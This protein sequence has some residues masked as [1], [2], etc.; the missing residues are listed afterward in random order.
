MVLLVGIGN[1]LKSDDNIG[2][3]V[4]EKLKNDFDILVAETNPEAYLSKMKGRDKIIFIDAVDFKGEIGEVQLFNL[5]DIQDLLYATHNIPVSMLKK[6]LPGVEIQVIG[7]QP[8][9]LEFGTELS[10]NLEE[11]VEKVLKLIL[12]CK[13]N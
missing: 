3:L 6:M 7:I 12:V 8:K 5:E 4:V 13:A 2:N 1:V 9:S 10:L 11:I